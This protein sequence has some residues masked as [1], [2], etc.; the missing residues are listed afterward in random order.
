MASVCPVP[1]VNAMPGLSK[2]K[3]VDVTPVILYGKRT[4]LADWSESIGGAAGIE[5]GESVGR[6]KMN[7]LVLFLYKANCV[8]TKKPFVFPRGYEFL[9]SGTN[10]YIGPSGESP[11]AETATTATTTATTAA[12]TTAVPKA[13]GAAVGGAGG[14]GGNSRSGGPSSSSAASK[15][16]API[17]AAT[18]ATV[19][20]VA[21]AAAPTSVSLVPS[22]ESMPVGSESKFVKVAKEL[23]CEGTTPLAEWFRY[24]RSYKR[25]LPGDSTKGFKITCEGKD[26][27]LCE[28]IFKPTKKPFVFPEGYIFL[29]S[30]DNIDFYVGPRSLATAVA[31]GAATARRRRTSRRRTSRRRTSRR[32][33]SRR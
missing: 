10:Y 32:R 17:A 6:R 23:L 31:T 15:P 9:T 3:L 29:A 16:N 30:Q 27:T 19:A 22:L 8:N 2:T 33:S 18:A 25:V 5:T 21:A 13:P 24:M 26:L 12:A 14:G 7:N 4:P 28:P 1:P 11:A 20:T